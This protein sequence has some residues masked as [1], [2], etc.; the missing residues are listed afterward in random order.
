MIKHWR[1]FD[2]ISEA[3]YRQ[4]TVAGVAVSIDYDTSDFEF[5]TTGR[6]QTVK[7]RDVYIST[8]NEKQETLIQLMFPGTLRLYRSEA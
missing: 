7:S 6:I 5:P 4:L 1:L 3:Q 8:I 2:D